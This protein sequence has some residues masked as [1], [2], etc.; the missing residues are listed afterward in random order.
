MALGEGGYAGL[1]RVEDGSLNLAAAVE[2]GALKRAGSPAAVV[3]R[4]V[5]DAGLANLDLS[6]AAWQ[7]TLPLTRQTARPVGHRIFVLGDAAGY[8]EPFTGEGIAWALAGGM[9]VA[10]LAVQGLKGWTRHVERAWLATYDE[11]VRNRQFWC[12]AFAAI[13]RRPWLARTAVELASA[14]PTLCHP[15]VERLNRPAR[16]L[17]LVRL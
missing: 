5:R 14:W 7:G 3:G 13:L 9:G 15:I 4:I 11:L 12:R 6:A 10:N 16:S 2:P 1:V 8:V 17:E